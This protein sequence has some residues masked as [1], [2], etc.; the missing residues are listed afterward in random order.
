MNKPNILVIMPDTFRGDS[1]ACAGHPAVQTPDLDRLASVGVRFDNAYT[2]SPICMPAR[3]NCISGLYCHNTGQW[4]NHGRFPAGT[5]TYMNVLQ[6]NGYHTAHIGKS[7]YYKHSNKRSDKAPHLDDYKHILEEMGHDDVFETTGPWATVGTDS[8]LTDRW[9]EKGLLE[10]F[11]DDYIKRR[12]VGAF[13]A[14]WPSPLPEEEH[15]DTFIGRTAV[16]YLKQYNDEKPFSVFV[17]IGGPHDPWDPPQ[18]WADRFADVDVP[19]PIPPTPP[20]EWLSD[21]ARAYHAAE[22]GEA[23]DADTWKAIRRLYYAKIAHLDSLVGEILDALEEEGEL[24]N[25]VIV[26]WSDHG[27]RL[28]DR[29]KH[30]KGVFYDESARVPLIL[31]LPGNP[32]AGTACNSVVS[33]N[34]IFPTVLGAAGVAGIDSFGESLVPAT[35][36]P[37]MSFHDAVFS[38]IGNAHARRTMIRTD[39][40]KMVINDSAETLQ[41][42]DMQEDPKELENLAN[43][44]DMR[45]L[46]RELRDR[47]FKWRL[48]TET[49]QSK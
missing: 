18:N 26:F 7:H 12:E 41:L 42:L 23:R 15:M 24:D 2:S 16:D 37:G 46:E 1:L 11:R 35:Q 33:I 43:R 10:L 25:T 49:V 27:D 39:R 30:A 4:T 32:G 14:T 8:I 36:D 28:C 20:E 31:R 40:Y 48:Q 13:K 38:E 44:E 19:E 3:S 47:I 29:G 5:R 22:M 45:E 21:A 34:D 17:G 9:R 6:E